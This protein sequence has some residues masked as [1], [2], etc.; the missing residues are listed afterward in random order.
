[1]STPCLTVILN[2]QGAEIVALYRH[3]DG[4][5]ETHGAELA[6][7]LAGF[8]IVNGLGGNDPAKVANGM[9]C[10][11]AQVVSHFKD[12]P[13]NI[14]L[15]PVGTRDCGERYIY[16]VSQAQE[17]TRLHV[18]RLARYDDEE[19]AVLFDGPPEQYQAWLTQRPA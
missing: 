9:E 8:A 6:A 10:L 18:F 4:A 13:G 14:Y 17:R 16:T 3:W 11:A 2:Q 7:F 12:T 5:P 15:H 19:N 1:M